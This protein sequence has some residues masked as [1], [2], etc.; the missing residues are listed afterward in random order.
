VS[1]QQTICSRRSTQPGGL[2]EQ[3]AARVLEGREFNTQPS[4]AF[5]DPD[6]PSTSRELDVFSYRNFWSGSEAK[7]GIEASVLVECKQ[8]GNPYCAIGQEPPEWRR[9]GNPFTPGAEH[10][11]YVVNPETLKR[12]VVHIHA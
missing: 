12:A 11:E 7:V 10:R 1:N 4:W 3:Q 6:Q 8:S 5:P 9:V 2:L